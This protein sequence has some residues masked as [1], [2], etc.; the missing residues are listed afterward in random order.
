MIDFQHLAFLLLW[1]STFVVANNYICNDGGPSMYIT[2]SISISDTCCTDSH[3]LHEMRFGELEKALEQCA[4]NLALNLAQSED[5]NCNEDRTE[6]VF[7]YDTFGCTDHMKTLCTQTGGTEVEVNVEITCNE[8]RITILNLLH[9]VGIL[10]NEMDI[11]AMYGAIIKMKVGDESRGCSAPKFIDMRIKENPV[12]KNPTIE[13][14]KVKD[15]EA[16]AAKPKEASVKPRTVIVIILASL[17]AVAIIMRLNARRAR[18]RRR[19]KRALAIARGISI[20]R[21]WKVRK[22]GGISGFIYNS[23]NY[24]DG[25]SIET[26]RITHGKIKNDSFV[27]TKSGT[28]YFLSS[29]FPRTKPLQPRLPDVT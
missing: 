3:D 12:V 7:N 19:T 9:C 20:I 22:D 21:G 4:S 16:E 8:K 29:E 1:G 28:K 5:D 27:S 2:E 13:A 17:A 6:C 23:Q 18:K 10:C 24:E 26:S 14:E 15:A 11:Q 25:D